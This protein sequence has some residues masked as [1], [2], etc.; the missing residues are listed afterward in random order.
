[1]PIALA[2][3]ELAHDD[4]ALDGRDE[5]IDGGRDAYIVDEGSDDGFANPVLSGR[6]NEPDPVRLK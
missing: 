1:M 4:T 3:R 6:T 2:G 5:D